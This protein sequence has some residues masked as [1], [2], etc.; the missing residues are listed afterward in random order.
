MS[1]IEALSISYEIA[2]GS[3]PQNLTGNKWALSQVLVWHNQGTSDK[4]SQGRPSCM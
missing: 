4:L 1:S 2:L 3:I